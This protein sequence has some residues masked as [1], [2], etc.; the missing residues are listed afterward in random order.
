[1]IAYGAIACNVVAIKV[2]FAALTESSRIVDE[3]NGLLGA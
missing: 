3:V 1:M 2:E